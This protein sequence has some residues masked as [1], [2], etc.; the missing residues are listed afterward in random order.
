V[1]EFLLTRSHLKKITS[2][3]S[4]I[5]VEGDWVEKTWFR[6][7][8]PDIQSIIEMAHIYKYQEESINYKECKK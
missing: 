4:L 7:A 6:Q 1:N 3:V 5:L 2:R 8:Q